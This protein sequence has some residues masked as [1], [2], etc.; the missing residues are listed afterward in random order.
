MTRINGVDM[1]CPRIIWALAPFWPFL[2]AELQ[3]GSRDQRMQPLF[4]VS[5]CCALTGCATQCPKDRLGDLL[6]E[7]CGKSV[8]CCLMTGLRK[9][10]ADSCLYTLRPLWRW[11]CEMLGSDSEFWMGP[12]CFGW[13]RIVDCNRMVLYAFSRHGGMTHRDRMSQ[14]Q[15][16]WLL[17]ELGVLLLSPLPGSESSLVSAVR[18]AS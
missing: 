13:L 16:G 5:A 10:M 2:P 7:V 15:R 9:I 12:W 8:V 4:H 17:T 18:E 1:L 3:R 14:R 6:S 11:K